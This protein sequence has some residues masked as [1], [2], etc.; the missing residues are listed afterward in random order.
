M[1]QNPK[2]LAVSVTDLPVS[3][4]RKSLNYAIKMVNG[5]YQL[6]RFCMMYAYVNNLHNCWKV[7]MN[8]ISYYLECHTTLH[9]IVFLLPF[10]S[11]LSPSP[12]P[13][14]PSPSLSLPSSFPLHLQPEDEET[15]LPHR[16]HASENTPAP[17][18]LEPALPL[19][20]STPI[21]SDGL[22]E[23][24]SCNRL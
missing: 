6:K 13:H 21:A 22:E 24:E 17:E 9:F 5:S 12:L 2:A 8:H 4:K 19:V 7:I 10:L 16:D 23:V 15:P 11:L 1:V 3:K 14:P 20:T 18:I